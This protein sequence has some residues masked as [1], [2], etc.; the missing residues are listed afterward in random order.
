MQKLGVAFLEVQ[1]NPRP[2]GFSTHHTLLGLGA[3]CGLR[4]SSL[5]LGALI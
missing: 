3:L 2:V 5:S 4:I 1:L